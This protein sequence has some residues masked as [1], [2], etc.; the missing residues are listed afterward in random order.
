VRQQCAVAIARSE[1]I[2]GQMPPHA[3][4]LHHVI[5]RCAPSLIGDYTTRR[6][7]CFNAENTETRRCF[8]GSLKGFRH[9]SAKAR[10]IQPK[11]IPKFTERQGPTGLCS[12]GRS[13]LHP[14][15][16]S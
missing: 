8:G 2:T 11:C 7:L 10:R 12:P 15:P 5:N 16:R 3:R 6:T 4:N 13:G 1:R 9:A 14:T